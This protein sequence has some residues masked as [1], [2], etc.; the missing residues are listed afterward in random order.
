MQTKLKPTFIT[1]TKTVPIIN[2]DRATYFQFHLCSPILNF[3]QC[4]T[5]HF[6]KTDLFI[7]STKLGLILHNIRNVLDKTQIYV[8]NNLR[9]KL[10]NN[11]EN[12]GTKSNGSLTYFVGTFVNN[13]IFIYL[14]SFII[15]FF[16]SVRF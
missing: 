3:I 15:F 12:F 14:M 1:E 8:D 13:F 9:V 11:I 10:L 6:D 5:S 7:C 4:K 2:L 16:L